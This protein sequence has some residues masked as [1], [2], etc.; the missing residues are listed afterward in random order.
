MIVIVESTMLTKCERIYTKNE[1]IYVHLSIDAFP[2][3]IGKASLVTNRHAYDIETFSLLL[4]ML[5]TI[6]LQ[7]PHTVGLSSFDNE[8]E[9][10]QFFYLSV[11][12][13]E[14]FN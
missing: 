10:C 3:E 4:W 1:L 13:N 14:A 9:T 8:I 12:W 7:F 5:W 6:T 2:F 11:E